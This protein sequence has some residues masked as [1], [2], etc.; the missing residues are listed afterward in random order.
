MVHM[1]G[2]LHLLNEGIVL[3]E[4]DESLNKFLEE[5]KAHFLVSAHVAHI[6]RDKLDKED[7]FKNEKR[8]MKKKKK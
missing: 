6:I 8:E 2:E 5:N 7:I 3:V 4:L 1:E